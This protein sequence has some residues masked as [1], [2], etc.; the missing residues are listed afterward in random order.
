M[1]AQAQSAAKRGDVA[2]RRQTGRLRLRKFHLQSTR[3]KRESAEGFVLNSLSIS[4]LNRSSPVS[5]PE[6]R[7]VAM[8]EVSEL[9]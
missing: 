8:P 5:R 7:S 4:R 9:R 3:D 1:L 2:S 6:V